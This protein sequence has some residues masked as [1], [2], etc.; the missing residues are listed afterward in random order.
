MTATR[1]ARVAVVG[2]GWWACRLHL[3]ALKQNPDAV[4]VALCDQ[5]RS[6]V[7]EAARIF[8]VPVAVTDVAGVIDAGVDCAIV[9]TPHDSHFEPA[10]ALLD[11]GIDVLVEKPMTLDPVQAWDLVRRAERTGARLH[12]GYPF[13]HSPHLT[14]LRA[15][16]AGGQL[17]APVLSQGLF[18]TGVHR[19]L[20]GDVSTQLEHGGLFASSASTYSDPRRGGGQMN[21]QMTHAVAVMLSATGLYPKSVSA[22]S[23]FGGLQ[24]DLA[25]SLAVGMSD[26]SVATIATTGSV[27]SHEAR[28]EEYRF[29]AAGGHACLDTV[30]GRLGI[31]RGE[32]PLRGEPDLT[33]AEANPERATS[34]ALVAAA[35]DPDRTRPLAA[36]GEIGADVV[37]LL[38]AAVESATAGKPVEA[39]R[40]PT[41]L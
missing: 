28:I 35:I 21:S 34:I 32:M 8:D 38:A 27:L 16:L 25:D 39:Y 36:P 26:G 29:F 17:G 4:V 33:E 3:V 40:P 2:V 37:A 20:A 24:V 23:N 41:A 22:Y 7:D 6:R 31:S 10:A 14:R 5:D 15:V 9:A 18:A 12:V 1:V 11:A 30:R 13:L 19:L